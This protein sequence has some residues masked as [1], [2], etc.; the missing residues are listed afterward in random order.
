MFPY[1]AMA[2]PE[3][4]PWL[5]I[6]QKGLCF[7]QWRAHGKD[8]PTRQILKDHVGHAVKGGDGTSD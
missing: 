6:Y 7:D 8:I 5:R 1:A 4:A 2:R 3:A